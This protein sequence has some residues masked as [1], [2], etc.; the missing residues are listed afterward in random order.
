MQ[1]LSDAAR[2]RRIRILRLAES[3]GAETVTLDGPTPAAAIL[4]YARVRKATRIVVGEPRRR[5][6]RAW[7]RPSTP[8]ALLDRRHDLDVSVIARRASTPD[9]GGSAPSASHGRLDAPVQWERYGWALAITVLC[10][11]IA[12]LMD[13]YFSNTNV[14]MVFLL[15]AAIAGLRLGRG[16]AS[17]TAVLNVASFDFFFVPPKLTFAVADAEY[18]ITFA[19]MLVVA[20]T[21]GTLTANVRQQTRVAGARERRTALLYAMSRE[22]AAARGRDELREIATRHVAATFDARAAVLLPDAQGRLAATSGNGAPSTYGEADPSVAQWVYDR[23]HAAGLGTDTLPGSAGIYLPLMGSSSTLGVLAV[24]PSRPRRVL[25]PEQRHLLETFA[26]Q[27]GL[28]LERAS[29]AESAEAARVSAEAESLRNTLLASISH[30][31]R[32]PLAVIAGASSALAD[33]AFDF[34]ESTRRELASSIAERARDMSAVVSNVLDLMRLEAGHLR[35]QRRWETL[36]DLIGVAL[37]RMDAQLGDRRV[38]VGLPGDLPPVHVD[39]ALVVQVFANL[40]ENVAK[41]TPP[42]TRVAIGAE[43]D[44]DFV[45]VVVDDTGPG[46]PTGD[47]SQLFDKFKRGSPESDVPGAGLGLAICRAVVAAH[48]GRIEATNLPGGGARFTLTL[49]TREPTP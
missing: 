20:L 45:R 37:A 32:T 6:W 26:A 17:L 24:L 11:I 5:G 9:A 42:T 3:L 10:T 28:A 49:P 44:G 25:L 16:P 30:D 13:P 43:V 39:G 27:I 22:L 7:L 21:I 14:V 33:P 35:L 19:V 47:P 4:E 40:L 48:G 46:L 29:L 12:A 38:E 8:V 18:V 15:G 23:G 41:H 36:D 31:L 2:D 1:R 34:D